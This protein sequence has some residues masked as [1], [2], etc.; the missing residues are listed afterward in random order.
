MGLALA[1]ITPLMRRKFLTLGLL[2]F[3]AGTGILP[4]QEY[5]LRWFG[6][7]EGLGTLDVRRIQQDRTGFLWAITDNGL[8]R[9]DGERFEGFGPKQGIPAEPGT[10]GEAPDGSLLAGGRFGLYRF[11]GN[12]FEKLNGIAESV[13]PAQGIQSDGHGTTYL[14]TGAGL[15]KLRAD[16]QGGYAVERVPQAPGTSGA[17]VEGILVDGSTVWYGCGGQLCRLSTQEDQ[18]GDKQDIQVFGKEAGLPG[19]P[20]TTLRKDGEGNLWVYARMQGVFKLPAGQSRFVSPDT[21]ED[22]RTL[23]PIVNVDRE[24]RILLPGAKGLLIGEKDGWHTVGPANGLRGEVYCAFEDRSHSLWIGMLGRGLVQWRGYQQW[25]NYSAASGLESDLVFSVLP[26][27]NH[28]V[29]VGTTEGLEQGVQGQFGIRWQKV[30]AV[31]TTSLH[32]I[33]AQPDGSLWFGSEEKGVGRYSPGT[34]RVEWWNLAKPGGTQVFAL[35]FDRNERLWVGTDTGLYMAA[36]PY[37]RFAQIKETGSERMWAVAEGSDGTIWAGGRDGLFAL[38]GDRWKKFGKADGLSD[39]AVLSLG[40]APDGVIWV[41]YEYGGGIDRVHP[42]GVRIRVE[43]GI[44]RPGDDGS[45]SFLARDAHGQVWA[46]TEHGVDVWNGK[47]WTHIDSQ[48]GLV[49]NDCDLDAFAA[50]P[51]GTVWIGTSG[52]LSR[53]RP[54]QTADIP[55]APVVVFTRVTLGKNEV[56]PDDNEIQG[57]YAESIDVR[58][59][60]LN[61]ERQGGV[62]FR[63]RLDGPKTPWTETYQHE[64][65]FPRLAPGRYRLD[66]EAQDED[67]DWNSRPAALRFRVLSPW[68]MTWWFYAICALVPLAS[69]LALLR[70]R[71]VSLRRE[72]ESFQKLKDAH[73]EIRTLAFYDPLTALPNRRLLTDRLERAIATCASSGRL[74]GLL[75]VDLDNFK[76]LN[77]SLGHETGDLLLKEAAGRLSALVRENGTVA[78][79]GGDEFVVLLEDLSCEAA[80][81]AQGAEATAKQILVTLGQSY[82]LGAHHWQITSSIGITVFGRRHES[83]QEALKQADIAMYQAK[84]AGQNSIRFFAPELQAAINARAALEVELRHALRA[85]QFLLY[86]QPQMID[87]AVAGAEVLI[88][89]PHPRR[90]LLPPGEFIPLAEETGL[91]LPLG[92]WVLNA[93]CAQ[94]A[95]WAHD[96]KTRALQL[97]VN[98]SARQLRQPDFVEGVLRALSVNGANPDLLCLELTESLL[99][100]NVE[101]VIEKMKELHRH[102]LRL[103]LDDFGTGYSSLT[104]LKRLPL[105]ELKIDRSF[106]CD[107]LRN[108]RGRAVVEAIIHLSSGLGLSVLAEGVETEEQRAFLAECGCR[109]YQGFLISPP[110]PVKGFEK[111]ASAYLPA[112]EAALCVK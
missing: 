34:G 96:E 9:Y 3:T 78:R 42:E 56:S 74:C 22:S 16:S 98:I 82:R 111:L 37:S 17:N 7:A 87:R 47:R 90:G 41:G 39:N 46:G 28:V 11:R 77:D 31:G 104:Y 53:M 40:A 13:S 109:A 66:V 24:G 18:Q 63:Y 60:A 106:V 92:G 80:K 59:S 38:Y 32:S 112:E 57:R 1:P 101:E 8:Y 71:I 15:V 65:H 68:Y 48:D 89:W 110:L 55:T 54:R 30:D 36:A 102:G 51:D 23:R 5:S 6:N 29:W 88:R 10:I 85:G 75:F 108:L 103:S 45:V 20:I 72:E 52:G 91:I 4:A 35:H 64:L 100:E 58:F 44:E 25:E 62:L 107:M 93:A 14:G 76:T 94:L 105:D 97:A 21:P 70:R 83:P 79:L 84:G 49:W 27:P 73:D 26:Q 86:F 61:V 43:K 2:L 50:E 81:A 19:A 69:G 99:V 33:V 12:H 95:L 67:E